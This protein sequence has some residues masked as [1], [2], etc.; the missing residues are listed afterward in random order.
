MAGQRER[1]R[2]TDAEVAE[3]LATERTLQVASIGP[4]GVPHLV[5]MWFKVIAGRI[6]MWTYAKSQKAANLQR[7]P[8]VTCLVEAGETYGELRG[9]SITGMADLHDDYETVFEVGAALYGRYQGDMTH[10]SR[11]GVE[12]EA[13]KRVAIFVD[14][15]KTASWDH[16]KL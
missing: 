16:R 7:D 10:A 2:M 13:R 3:F 1:I 9:V 12:A 11:A 6:A 15:V 5:P 4:D 8:R 14:P